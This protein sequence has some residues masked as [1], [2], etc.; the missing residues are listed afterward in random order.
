MGQYHLVNLS[1]SPTRMLVGDGNLTEVS[2]ERSRL[3]ADSEGVTTNPIEAWKSENLE[4]VETYQLLGAGK[5]LHV[6]A[7]GQWIQ[8]KGRGT[9][10]LQPS[11]NNFDIKVDQSV[12]IA[13]DGSI[14]L[15][16]GQEIG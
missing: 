9:F 11:S 8:S 2:S 6:F 12:E 7:D 3:H 13:Q 16:T 15:S 10:A 4:M 1:K 14:K 5:V